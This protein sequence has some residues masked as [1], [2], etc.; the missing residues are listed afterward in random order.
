[1]VGVDEQAVC[2][3]LDFEHALAILLMIGLEQVAQLKR[4]PG[5]VVVPIIASDDQPGALIE[6]LQRRRSPERSGRAGIAIEKGL[7][8]LSLAAGIILDDVIGIAASRDVGR[9]S[10]QQVE[11][12]FS[13]KG[14]RIRIPI[15]AVV[16][17]I[18]AGLRADE[19]VDRLT[20]PGA[21]G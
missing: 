18:L 1:G 7:H 19:T 8:G 3:A 14:R 6:V 15:S 5:G 12:I 21:F 11:K 2:A 16:N 10:S 20:C 4:N 17:E 9:G 13:D